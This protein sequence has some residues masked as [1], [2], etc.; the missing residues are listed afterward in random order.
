MWDFCRGKDAGGGVLRQEEWN[1]E[2]GMDMGGLGFFKRGN[3]FC[4][5]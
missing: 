1:G 5:L 4:F 3:E 2:K